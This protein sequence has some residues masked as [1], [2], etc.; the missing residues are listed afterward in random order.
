MSAFGFTGKVDVYGKIKSY[1]DDGKP[2][3]EIN[4]KKRKTEITLP[5]YGEQNAKNFLASFAVALEL[6]LSMN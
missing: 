5:V 6:G 3:I 2:I 1:T 4:Y